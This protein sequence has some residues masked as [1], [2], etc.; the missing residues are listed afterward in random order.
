M[1]SDVKTAREETSLTQGMPQSTAEV[2]VP[3]EQINRWP[4]QV[5][6]IVGNEACERF[7]YYGMKAILALYIT[8]VLLKTQDD[9]TNIIALFSAANYFMPLLG[10]WVS[11]RYWGRYHTILWI[12][13]SY[14]VG[15]AILATSDLIPTIEGKSYALYAGLALIAF[16]SGGI[17]PCVSAFMG[18]QFKPEQR[19]LLQKAYAAFYWSINLGS[20]FAFFAIPF[21]RKHFGYGWAFGVPGIAMAIATFIFWSGTRFYVRVPPSRE[22]KHA[23][24]IKVFSAALSNQQ[25]GVGVAYLNTLTSIF[26]PLIS[27]VGLAFV[28]FK[29]EMTYPVRVINWIALGCIGLWYLL[30]VLLSLARRSELPDSF[31]NAA[32]GK[33]SDKEISAAR[34]V[35]PILFVFALVPI[36]WAL[37]DQTFSTWVLQGERMT[38]YNIGQLSIGPE[39][40]LAANPMLVMILIPIMTWGLYPLMGRLVT[41]LR[42]M[43]AGMFLAGFS[44]IIV[45]MLQARIDA[46]AHLSILWQTAPYVVLTIAEVLVSTTGL[47]F[48]FREAAPEMKSIIN[49]FWNL[50]ITMGNLMV[51]GITKAFPGTGTEH[52]ASVS[53]GRFML[54]AG[55]TFVVAILFSVIAAF[56]TYRDKS[57]AEGK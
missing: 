36:F 6:F 47:E 15:H 16:G 51:V 3:S 49:G 8:L 21:T 14:C 12:S 40:M 25:R 37:F 57:A 41:P 5:K 45:A 34:S 4:P 48:A 10:A 50:T 13:L 28:G 43:S 32:R 31:W 56:Y 27:I 17:K 54:Y 42:R 2:S 33:H 19:H 35:A 46:G 52:N 7:S 53:S 9:A 11:D 38:Q 29:H 30:T 44:Y 55:L 24:F 20:F 39:E 1:D 22:T 26:L 23:G 18:D